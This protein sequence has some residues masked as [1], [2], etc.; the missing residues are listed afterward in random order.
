MPR[1]IRE[2]AR[3]AGISVRTLHHYDEIGLVRPST[4]SA[5]GYRLY[6]SADL[7][8]LQQVLFFRE[9]DFPLEEIERILNDPKF[10]VAA[11]LRMQRHLLS[12]R[13]DRTAALIR[14]VDT[15]LRT[16]EGGKTMTDEDR[17]AG[18]G[19]F[20]PGKYETEAQDRWGQTDAYRESARRTARY[21]PRD[22]A[23]IKAEGDEIFRA[24][25]TLAAADQPAIGPAA[26]AVA[27]RHRQHIEQWFYACPPSLHRGLGELYVQDER[28]AANIDRYH[29]GLSAYAREAWQ[30]NARRAAG[31]D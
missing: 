19:D 30:A 6:E 27:E 10:D 8:R 7:D 15:A 1:K 23:Q 5:A 17:F 29:P 12:E 26:M 3:L 2:V 24:L 20:D 13:A 16:L 18:L 28:F 22:W 11:A 31:D 21:T 25:A 4:R 14:A 9:L